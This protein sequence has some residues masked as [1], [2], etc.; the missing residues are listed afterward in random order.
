[1]LAHRPIHG[2]SRRWL[3]FGRQRVGCCGELPDLDQLEA[4]R[5]DAVQQ[6]MERRLVLD[7]TMQHCLHR[8]D[9]GRQALEGRST[10]SLRRPLMWIS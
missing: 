10:E 2:P 1:M 7:R 9:S 5:L 6:A 8:L 4:E 3:G